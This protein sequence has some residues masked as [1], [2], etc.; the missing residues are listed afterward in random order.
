MADEKVWRFQDLKV[1]QEGHKF[2]I[3]GIS[4]HKKVPRRRK[5]QPGISNEA[6]RDF[7]PG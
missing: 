7:D 4:H 6:S 1:W 5:I 3:D 2:G